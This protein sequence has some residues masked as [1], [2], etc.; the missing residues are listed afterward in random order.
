MQL[1]YRNLYRHKAFSFNKRALLSTFTDPS[2]FFKGVGGK[3]ADEEGIGEEEA[4]EDE[5][6][7]E[8]KG[9][10]ILKPCIKLA[11]CK[12]CFNFNSAH[13]KSLLRYQNYFFHYLNSHYSLLYPR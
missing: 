2:W 8:E 7:D 3:G 6:T 5:G 10:F 13:V 9:K 11:V 4:G 1:A 12:L